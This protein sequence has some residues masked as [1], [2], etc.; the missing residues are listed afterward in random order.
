M[1][2]VVCNGHLEFG[3]RILVVESKDTES[4]PCCVYDSIIKDVVVKA[5]VLR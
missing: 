4:A 2:L 5:E 1:E 3:S